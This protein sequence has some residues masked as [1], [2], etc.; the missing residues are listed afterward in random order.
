VADAAVGHAAEVSKRRNGVRASVRAL[1]S[2]AETPGSDGVARAGDAGSTAD[3]ELVSSACRADRGAGFH[4]DH[5]HGPDGRVY[6]RTSN[7]IGPGRAQELLR[8]GAAMA[9]D[10]CGC[11]GH[12]GLE[13]PGP[14]ERIELARRPPRMTK[15]RFGW[16]DE[17]RSGDGHSLVLQNGDVRWP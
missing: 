17:W 1:S 4:G 14:A 6:R 5:L 13:W 11:G 16:L 2:S 10:D 7:Q 15:R 8:A 12:C 9:I 3:G